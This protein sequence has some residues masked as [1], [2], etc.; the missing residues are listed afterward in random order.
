MSAIRSRSARIAVR[1]CAVGDRGLGRDPP[2][3][4][5]QLHQSNV[6]HLDDTAYGGGGVAGIT[7]FSWARH[8]R[9]GLGGMGVAT[10]VAPVASASVVPTAPR[11]TMPTVSRRS[12][13]VVPARRPAA[14]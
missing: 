11:P 1:P 10:V 6:A 5:A 14:S 8:R 7:S 3:A 9:T 2:L 4:P 12:P 13:A